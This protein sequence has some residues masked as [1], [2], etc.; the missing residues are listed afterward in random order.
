MKLDN[1]ISSIFKPSIQS[2]IKNMVYILRNIIKDSHT[3]PHNCPK[4]S[5]AT[6]IWQTIK[7]RAA[8]KNIY[9]TENERQMANYINCHKGERVFIIGNGPSLNNCNLNL[10]KNEITFGVNSIYLNYENMGFY[11]TYYVVEDVFVAED[12]SNEINK[13]AGPSKFFGNYLK[14]CISDSEDTTWLNVRF[15]YDDYP[16]F[17]NFSRNA[18]R[19]LWTGGTVTYICLQLAYY[20]GFSEVYLVG[21]DHSYAVPSDAHVNGTEIIS[22]SDDPNHFNPNYFGKGYR[23]HDPRVD[24]MEKAYNKAK[25]I[26]ESENKK[27]YNA[28]VGGKLDVFERVDY[29]S[30]FKD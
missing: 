29:K 11:P 3:I 19:M 18:G 23:W 8:G 15:R 6:Q 14:Y 26:F 1:S 10:L 16:D 12:R 24:R 20:M 21:F 9:L 25:L 2:K 13:L 30:L 5:I 22:K 28:T 7:A 17:P 27:I 4:P